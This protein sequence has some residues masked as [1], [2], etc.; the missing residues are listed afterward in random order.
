[1][2]KKIKEKIIKKIYKGISNVYTFRVAKKE[3]QNNQ[4]IFIDTIKENFPEIKIDWNLHY[5]KGTNMPV[6]P[7]PTY[8][9]KV[10]KYQRKR[11]N[12]LGR[13]AK[14]DQ[15]IN[16]GGKKNSS[17][18]HISPQQHLIPEDICTISIRKKE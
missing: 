11:E 7:T 18:L 2:F 1:M 13:Q 12:L 6:Y 14:K 9:S 10:T 5:S 16:N 8:P 4:K 17:W 15:I 3:N